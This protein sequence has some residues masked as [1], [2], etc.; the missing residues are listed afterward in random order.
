[1]TEEQKQKKKAYHKAR[2]SWPSVR[3]NHLKC[4]AQRRN[5]LCTLTLDEYKSLIEPNACT[6]C[7]FPLN[8]TGA[9]L[10][11]IDNSKGYTHDNVVACC[12]KCNSARGDN[13]THAQMVRNIGPAIRKAHEEEIVGLL[14]FNNLF[15]SR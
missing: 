13:F 6:Y 12:W 14:T 3:F 11:R 1:M 10:D 9:S 7:E 2:N 4:D 5:L 15:C 8:E